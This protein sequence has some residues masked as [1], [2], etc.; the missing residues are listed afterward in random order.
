MIFA[1]CFWI[2]LTH[3]GI[4]LVDRVEIKPPSLQEMNTKIVYVNG[5]TYS[6]WRGVDKNTKHSSHLFDQEIYPCDKPFM[7]LKEHFF[8]MLCVKY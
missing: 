3:I 7:P 6:K 8:P 1:A 4:E 2:Q 5:K